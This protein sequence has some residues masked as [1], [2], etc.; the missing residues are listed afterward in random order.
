MK[1]D[2]AP[3]TDSVEAVKRVGFICLFAGECLPIDVPRSTTKP[4]PLQDTNGD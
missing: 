1:K 3:G 4:T 2:D